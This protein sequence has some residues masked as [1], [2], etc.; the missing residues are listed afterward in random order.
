MISTIYYVGSLYER[1]TAGG[2]TTHR[3]HLYAGGQAIGQLK[4][5]Q[6]GVN[7]FE[8]FHRDHQGSVTKVTN[9]AGSVIQS[10]SFDAFGK[11]RN[12]D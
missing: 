12:A 11:R 7:S 5:T 8:Y 10:L 1:E 9:G 2:T 6:A 4:R 3:H